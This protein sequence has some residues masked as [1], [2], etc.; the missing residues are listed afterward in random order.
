MMPPMDIQTGGSAYVQMRPRSD[1]LTSLVDVNLRADWLHRSEVLRREPK[2]ETPASA[3][4]C[5]FSERISGT[6]TIADLVAGEAAAGERAPVGAVAP[7]SG[8][9]SVRLELLVRREAEGLSPEEDA[10]L[11]IST[12]RLRKLLP[13]VTA[14]DFDALADV[15]QRIKTTAEET[16]ALRQELGLVD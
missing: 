15:A 5:S 4:S 14:A 3:V 8:E 12:E 6:R 9:A 7:G 1:D 2:E 11:K 16:A 10:R 13:R